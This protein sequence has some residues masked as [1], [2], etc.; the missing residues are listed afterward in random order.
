MKIYLLNSADTVAGLLR[1]C[2]MMSFLVQWRKSGD[3]SNPPGIARDP[4]PE[5]L[6]HL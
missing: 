4:E 6:M 2:L 3:P 5:L 1:I